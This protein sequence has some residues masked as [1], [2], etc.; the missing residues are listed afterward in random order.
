M[1]EGGED[2]PRGQQGIHTEGWWFSF[3]TPAQSYRESKGQKGDGVAE[4]QR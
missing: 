1:M 4:A 2:A 3:L